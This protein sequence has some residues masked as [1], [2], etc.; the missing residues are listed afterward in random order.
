MDKSSSKR[1]SSD[2]RQEH[3]F[4]CSV[5]CLCNSVSAHAWCAGR[6]EI[7][8]T[9]TPYMDAAGQLWSLCICA[10]WWQTGAN[11]LLDQGLI[12]AVKRLK[13]C[14]EHLINSR[15][16]ERGSVQSAGFSNPCIVW[17]CVEHFGHIRDIQPM[18]G[19]Q[20]KTVWSLVWCR[21]G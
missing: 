18:G 17:E 19:R 14:V 12:S 8:P 15:R 2:G 4:H 13:R 20:P 16:Q 7:Y 9:C 6:S 21:L 1:K 3:I 11:Y 10:S 5:Q